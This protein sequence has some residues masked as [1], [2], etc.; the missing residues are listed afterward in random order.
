MKK[1]IL[2][3]SFSL[4][5]LSTLSLPS[6]V[7]A[8][9]SSDWYTLGH[10]QERTSYSSEDVQLGAGSN[11]DWY[12]PIEAYIPQN[13]QLIISNDKLY[14]STAR[15]LYVFNT[16]NGSLLCRFDTELPLGNSPTVIGGIAYVGGYDKKLHAIDT[17]NISNGVCT[18]KA[19]WPFKGATA[20]YST[21]P[22]VDTATNTVYG[23]NRDGRI[24]AI[25]TSGS[26]KWQYPLAGQSPLGS[27][28]QTAAYKNNTLYFAAM[29]NFAYAI[30]DNGTAPQLMWKSAKLPGS[31]YQTY[32]A[33]LYQDKVVFPA[34]ISH[35][36]ERSPGLR[37]L[38][39]N[40]IYQLQN[41]QIFTGAAAGTLIGPTVSNQSWANGKTV[42]DG[43]TRLAKYF[44]TYPDR[45]ALIVL[46]QSDGSE[47]TYTFNS[48][49]YTIP[50]SQTGTHSGTRY[51]PA[52][53]PNDNLLYFTNIHDSSYISGARV[54]GW[55]LGTP[56]LAVASEHVAID[57]PQSISIGGN[58]LYRSRCCDRLGSRNSIVTGS[59]GVN[60]WGYGSLISEAPNYD[61]M[62]WGTDNDPGANHERLLGNYGLKNTTSLNLADPKPPL[63]TDGIYHSHG[64]QNPIVPY[65]G[66][67][68]VHRS[69]AILAFGNGSTTTRPTPLLRVNAVQ[70][71]PATP[72][73]NELKQR[74]ETEVQKMISAGMLR[75]GYYPNGQI[76][77]KDSLHLV[78][79]FF[80]PGDTLT[81]LSR[82]FPYLT[83]STQAQ[84]KT[85]LQNEYTM[86]FKN[87]RWAY[88]GWTSAEGS[89][90][91]AYPLPTDVPLNGAWTNQADRTRAG[92]NW[93]SWYYPQTSFYGLWLY[94]KNVAPEKT[95]EIYN[96]AKG[97]VQTGP[98][99][100]DAYLKIW[101][102][103]FNG[104]LAGYSGF[105]QLQD[106]AGMST[107]DSSLR[108][109]VISQNNRLL[110]L[111]ASSFT[112][113]SH[114]TNPADS[115]TALY[116]AEA[117]NQQRSFNVSHNFIW[118]VPEVAAYLKQNALTKVQDAVDEYNQLVPYWFV[119][120]YDATFNEGMMQ[121][122]YDSTMLEAKAWMLGASREE[123]AKYLDVPAF[124][125]GDLFYINNLVTV[126]EAPS[127]GPTPTSGPSST[128]TST[129]IPGDVNREG[130]VNGTDL[131][132]ILE[133]YITSATSGED[134]NQDGKVNLLDAVVVLKNWGL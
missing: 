16:S 65:K 97:L 24:Y 4:F 45:K 108:N 31:G 5:L 92:D 12:Q 119:S 127:S 103:E 70:D 63:G 112:K 14:V 107:Q 74:L 17:N 28:Q 121:T 25:N 77:F 120:G 75:P 99:Q 110:S 100:G 123:L 42:L 91:E 8:Q 109:Q 13:S 35:R 46:N 68:Y 50:V 132:L 82:A 101:T 126:L 122:L 128:P 90:R 7:Y 130:W 18:D 61:I 29:D 47:Y 104:F 81:A 21:A 133:K 71:M 66:R 59:G 26:L 2:L 41:E 55:K 56:Y 79:Y 87:N 80:L 32:W 60:M 105:L 111:R 36:D 117:N 78:D 15:G 89:G 44:N 106:K 30:K 27:I 73:D 125:R 54:M 113:T 49:T 6:S 62:W 11:V 114:W 83:S 38:P 134:I 57:E 39:Q 20:G 23:L 43:S 64:A 95:L 129:P 86:Y 9:T 98:N 3:I 67:L 48:T 88:K 10:D 116:P 93:D 53:N 1:Y 124:E 72:S 37:D 96:F 118:L 51:P 22:I 58:S 34:A 52:V 69:N 40:K 94:A 76:G 85:Y 102:H 115:A 131:L 19:G 84:V 33:V